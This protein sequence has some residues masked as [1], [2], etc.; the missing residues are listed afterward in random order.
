MSDGSSTPIDIEHW[1]ERLAVLAG[2][3]GVPGAQ[4]GIVRTPGPDRPAAR[5]EAAHGVLDVATGHAVDTGSV[6][7]IGSITKVWTATVVMGLVE[8]GLLSLDTSVAEA[9]PEA[10]PED[11]GRAAPITVGRL[12]DHTSGIDG[13]LF[14][15]TGRGDDALERYVGTLAEA[16]TIHPPGVGFSYCNSGFV[17]L[18]RII[19]KAT[20]LTWDEAMRERLFAPL[21]LTRAGTLP[22]EAIP[23]G[24]AMGHVRGYPDPERA[25]VWGLPRSMGPAGGVTANAG[26]L[27]RFAEAHLRGGR[28]DSGER[29]LSEETVEMMTRSRVT[30]PDPYTLGDSWGLGWIRYGWDGRRLVGHDGNTIGQSAFLRLLPDAGIAVALLTN[31]GRARDLYQELYGEVFERVAGTRVPAP[32]APD[33]DPE[34]LSEEDR[35][36]VSEVYENTSQRLEVLGRDG[37]RRGLRVIDLGALG[38]VDPDPV[39]EHPLAPID[40]GLYVFRA[41]DRRTWTPV[42]FHTLATG[43]RHLHLGGRAVP[44][45]DGEGTD[46][47]SSTATRTTPSRAT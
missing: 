19:E 30:L 18:G 34:D 9:V 15:D 33:H 38:G 22:E 13:D 23:H 11:P 14:T 36:S 42:T 46:Q 43:E 44:E 16:A 27:L 20:G 45:V 31:G 41:K 24:A 32:P 21:G 17:L 35:A 8:E 25:P 2:R 47:I 37:A 3:H 26:D 1:R 28:T 4:L 40:D 29:I 6:F 5:A 39:E 10:F 7:Q 12:L